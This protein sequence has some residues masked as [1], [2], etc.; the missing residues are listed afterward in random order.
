[1]LL[2]IET[3]PGKKR[4]LEPKLQVRSIFYMPLLKPLLNPP[5]VK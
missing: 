2:K 3:M 4:T 1:M 5:R